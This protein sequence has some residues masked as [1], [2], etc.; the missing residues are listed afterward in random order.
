MRK[1][2]ERDYEGG[3]TKDIW[4][5]NQLILLN[6]HRSCRTGTLASHRAPELPCSAWCVPLSGSVTRP[7]ILMLRGLVCSVRGP[8]H[9]CQR[10]ADS[11]SQ[12]GL[13]R[14]GSSNGCAGRYDAGRVRD[15][16]KGNAKEIVLH[17]ATDESERHLTAEVAGNY[18]G[19]LRLAEEE[20]FR[21]WRETLVGFIRAQR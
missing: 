5:D 13:N 17:P 21:E 19:L 12:I 10:L 1:T 3:V 2:Q 15:R 4:H 11:K 8:D 14:A 18:T 9:V 20:N 7:D 16:S 6:K